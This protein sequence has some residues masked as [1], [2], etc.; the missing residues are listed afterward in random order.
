MVVYVLIQGMY[1]NEY[2]TGVYASALDA[3]DSAMG[4]WS[5]D[6]GRWTNDLDWDDAAEVVGYVVR[7]EAD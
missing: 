1:E 3:M 7:E 6:K 5:G 4:N 2:P